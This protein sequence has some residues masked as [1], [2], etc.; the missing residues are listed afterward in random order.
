MRFATGKDVQPKRGSTDLCACVWCVCVS[1]CVW[2]AVPTL[3]Y[4]SMKSS[5][6]TSG[7]PSSLHTRAHA[8]AS[9][10][11]GVIGPWLWEK[12]IDDP[13]RPPKDERC[14]CTLR[15]S[16]LRVSVLK[17]RPLGKTSSS[18]CSKYCSSHGPWLCSC[19]Q[20]HRCSSSDAQENIATARCAADI[21]PHGANLASC[22]VVH[23]EWFMAMNGA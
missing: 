18:S 11:A 10:V 20:T 2:M 15:Y 14:M 1:V 17:C 7:C 12:A 6:I 9:A 8:K 13:H 4:V 5:G 22:M 16:L 3:L 19:A 23:Y 21:Q